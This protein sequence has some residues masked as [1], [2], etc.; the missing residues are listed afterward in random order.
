MPHRT[1]PLPA[2]ASDE[3]AMGLTKARPSG[4][5]TTVRAPLRTTIAR[6]AAA[7][8]RACPMRSDWTVRRVEAGEASH[9]RRM[10]RQDPR[11]RAPATA[12]P[13]RRSRAR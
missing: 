9:L 10:R 2:V 4:D 5:A 8:R 11:R 7:R 6:V 3:H 12:P 13:A 1:S